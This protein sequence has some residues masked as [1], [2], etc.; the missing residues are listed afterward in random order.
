MTKKTPAAVAPRLPATSVDFNALDAACKAGDDAARAFGETVAAAHRNRL[1][2][3]DLAAGEMLEDASDA[4]A[5]K[6]VPT[7]APEAPAA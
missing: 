7:A 1:Q 4:A 3:R 2:P 5:I 6:G